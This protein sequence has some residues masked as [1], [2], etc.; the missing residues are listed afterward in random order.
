M[1]RALDVLEAR[2]EACARPSSLRASGASS[3]RCDRRPGSAPVLEVDK[4]RGR[5][6][7]P[8]RRPR[9]RSRPGTGLAGPLG[10]TKGG[11]GGWLRVHH[12][13]ADVA[14]LRILQD[15]LLALLAGGTLEDDAPTC[16]ELAT[17]QR[18]GVGDGRTAAG[19]PLAALPGGRR[20]RRA[21]SRRHDRR[22][23]GRPVLD[24]AL[25]RGAAPGRPVERVAPGCR[26]RRL[27]PGR[28]RA[29]R[30]TRPRGRPDRREP[31]DDA[32][33]AARVVDQPAGPDPGASRAGRRVRRAGAAT[34]VVDARGL[35]AR[36]LRRRRAPRPARRSAD[37]AAG[38]GFRYFF[39]F[40]DAVQAREPAGIP[41]G[42]G[43]WAIDTRTSGRRQ[44]VH[45]LPR[46]YRR[47]AAALQAAGA[48]RRAAL[49]GGGRAPD[50]EDPAF[51]LT[52]QDILLQ[53]AASTA[54]S[55]GPR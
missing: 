44:R 49:G 1:R 51:L 28:R 12:M 47:L 3:R 45:R 55:G 33:P 37:D 32:I 48:I 6:G 43:G 25:R 29:G 23:V 8:T 46:L 9:L 18:D 10:G 30:A 24:P 53:E 16:R 21:G 2:H 14:G 17:E 42:P 7:D 22:A 41:L 39:N 34:P 11:A 40:S 38:A 4:R 20:S 15:E 52:F 35:P 19:R 31:D 27:L 36:L 54:A 13:V 50:G 26:V 5:R